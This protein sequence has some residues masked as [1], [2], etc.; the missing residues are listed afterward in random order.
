MLRD[1]VQM[2]AY[3]GQGDRFFYF[4]MSVC[5]KSTSKV[6]FANSPL[7]FLQI[8]RTLCYT[9]KLASGM[10][11]SKDPD[12]A[13][14]LAIFSSKMSQTRATLRLLDDLPMLSYSLSY[15]TGSK[16][17][18]MAFLQ[19]VTMFTKAKILIIGTRQNNGPYWL[20]YQHY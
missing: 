7:Y 15:G 20:H 10:Y 14:K 13:K 1:Q 19:I 6:K 17:L 8:V 9:T 18:W 2:F 12:F 11:S 4:R 3:V 16:V 5:K